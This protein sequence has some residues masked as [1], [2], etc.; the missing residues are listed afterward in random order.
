MSKSRN[1]CFTLNNYT[2]EEENILITADCKYLVMGKEVG[3]SGT[4][5]PETPGDCIDGVSCNSPCIL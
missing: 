1:F 4:P 3:E 5:L 2:E